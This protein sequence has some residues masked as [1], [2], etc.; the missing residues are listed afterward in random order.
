MGEKEFVEKWSKRLDERV[1]VEELPEFLTEMLEDSNDYGSIARA[2]GYGAVVTARAMDRTP[3]GGIT[4]FQA[5]FAMWTFIRE[6]MYP[7]NKCGLVLRDYDKMLYPQD[8]HYFDKTINE[9][10]WKSI[11]EEAQKNLDSKE[12]ASTN[13]REH[14]RD[15]VEGIVPFGYT[16]VKDWSR[17]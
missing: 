17:R 11:Q 6:W 9:S 3:Q 4:G 5:G 2:L 8:D 13:V 10:T 12:S 1:T 15:I 14:W 7:L 16:V